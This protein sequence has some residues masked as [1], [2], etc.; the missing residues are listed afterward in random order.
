MNLRRI[1]PLVSTI[2]LLSACSGG[3]AGTAG[4]PVAASAPR[5]GSASGMVTFSVNQT[6]LASTLHTRTPK[7][8]SPATHKANLFIDADSPTSGTCNTSGIC[9]IFWTTTPGNNHTFVAET[10]DGTTVLAEGSTQ[11]TI[12]AGAGNNVT[13]TLNGVV[14]QVVFPTTNQPSDESGVYAIADAD[15]FA[16]TRPGNFDN[17][18]FADFATSDSTGV[19]TT[20]IQFTVPDTLGNDYGFHVLC[21]GSSTGTFSIDAGPS[22][23]FLSGELTPTQLSLLTYGPVY[24]TVDYI[25]DIYACLNGVLSTTSG[26]VGFH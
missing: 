4:V 21:N 12:V 22:T 7:F 6:H 24:P 1:A 3:S 15:G 25:S 10:D 26:T 16:I 19:I 14:G 9:T 18:N 8:I 2:A 20:A 23:R 11:P 17:L 13:I 5:T